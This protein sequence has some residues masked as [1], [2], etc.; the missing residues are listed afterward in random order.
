[1]L[2][3]RGGLWLRPHA[4]AAQAERCF[5]LLPELPA[6]VGASAAPAPP[7]TMAAATP[8]EA[9]AAAVAAQR[10]ATLTEAEERIAELLAATF[11]AHVDGPALLESAR[12]V[13]AAGGA[14]APAALPA[15]GWPREVAEAPHP[16]RRR[17]E[18]QAA[19]AAVGAAG[20]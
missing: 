16:K 3:P 8:A 5:G 4:R 14:G 1:V 6:L 10:A 12:A 9:K 2:A 7:S 20:G 15:V 18:I 19:A 17:A 13:Q 11:E